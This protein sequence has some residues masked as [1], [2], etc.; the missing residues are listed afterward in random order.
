MFSI[1]TLKQLSHLSGGNS[2]GHR[3]FDAR[4]ARLPENHPLLN[5]DLRLKEDLETYLLRFGI[6]DIGAVN[7][8]QLHMFLAAKNIV[9]LLE[10]INLRGRV[11]QQ[12]DQGLQA[13]FISEGIDASKLDRAELR[14][15]SLPTHQVDI[16]YISSLQDI[17]DM[18][19]EYWGLWWSN[20]DLFV[21]RLLKGQIPRL[22]PLAP[23]ASTQEQA[24][25]MREIG[26]SR[27]TVN[28]QYDPNTKEAYTLLDVSESTASGDQRGIVMR[29]M[30]LA[31][32]N[33][34]RQLEFSL[35][36]RA[37]TT[38]LAELIFGADRKAFLAIVEKIIS[39]PASG[40]TDIQHALQQCAEDIAQ[41]KSV[42][43]PEILIITDGA[44]RLT[45]NPLNGAR[46][47]TF[48]VEPRRTSFDPR[49][50][51]EYSRSTIALMNWS[52]SSTRFEAKFL[53]HVLRPS[54]SD[55]ESFRTQLDSLEE[56]LKTIYSQGMFKVIQQRVLNIK[57]LL[58]QYELHGGDVSDRQFV[59]LSTSVKGSQSILDKIDCNTLVAANCA[60]LN[61]VD[62][63]NI[64]QLEKIRLQ[65]ASPTSKSIGES[66][67]VSMA[68]L[69]AGEHIS[70]ADL[71]R[72]MIRAIQ[73]RFDVWQS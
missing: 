59:E 53:P 28:P 6:L 13:N 18:L 67:G 5:P 33:E 50:I 62:L 48:I 38:E 49:N 29:G 32:T 69:A 60:Q 25:Q 65:N 46:L 26:M 63:E 34:A 47:H 15:A 36:F 57:Y 68:S 1:A 51:D 41:S 44:S 58:E 56:D 31:F 9:P 22:V 8:Q 23:Q 20:P 16:D 55:L 39:Q 3:T 19:P 73:R 70:L 30:A 45:E 66:A 64:R 35:R 52:S 27:A 2:L 4:E 7:P 24:E 10:H 54:P 40:Q 37:F 14:E 12:A 11:N 72:M 21:D 43:P 71:F 42:F 17:Y 61:S